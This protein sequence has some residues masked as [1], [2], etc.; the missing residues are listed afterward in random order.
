[1]DAIFDIL[2]WLWCPVAA[3]LVQAI[4]VRLYRPRNDVQETAV[5]CLA[6]LAS[7]VVAMLFVSWTGMQLYGFQADDPWSWAGWFVLSISPFG[8]PLL[9]GAPVVVILKV[10][11]G[12]WRAVTIARR[13]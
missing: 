1:M 3:L 9:F 11:L 13:R 2:W 12:W 4:A 8:L 5:G 6:W 10:L 7:F